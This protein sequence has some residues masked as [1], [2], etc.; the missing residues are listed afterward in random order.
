MVMLSSCKKNYNCVCS[1]PNGTLEVV[2]FK[3]NKGKAQ[4]KCSQY[5]DQHYGNVAFN[6]VKCEIK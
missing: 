4:E 6:Q 3:E 2:T 1:D 5:Y